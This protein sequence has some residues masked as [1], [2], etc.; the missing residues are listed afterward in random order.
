MWQ[1]RNPDCFLYT[2]VWDAEMRSDIWNKF[3]GIAHKYAYPENEE[4]WTKTAS[5]L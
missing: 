5:I 2:T 1:V 3:S 4:Q